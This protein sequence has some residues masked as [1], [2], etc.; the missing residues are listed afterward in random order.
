MEEEATVEL[1][2]NIVEGEV[3]VEEVLTDDED[4]MQGESEVECHKNI[5]ESEEKIE[6][7]TNGKSRFIEFSNALK[8][9][10][11]RCEE[12]LI[13]VDGKEDSITHGEKY[14]DD[15]SQNIT[16]MI[17]TSVP[18]FGRTDMAQKEHYKEIINTANSFLSI[19]LCTQN[20]K[21]YNCTKY[22][23][24][25]KAVQRRICTSGVLQ[26]H[27]SSSNKN[28]FETFKEK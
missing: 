7:K 4:N 9:K 1:L 19:S 10:N 5:K 16:A 12:E 23:K 25:S 15:M 21:T 13:K 6:K 27:I 26:G 14:P 8:D 28:V 22:C 17:H 3:I 20:I 18:S 2:P 24:S 11:I